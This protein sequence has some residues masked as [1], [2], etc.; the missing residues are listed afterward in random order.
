MLLK[1]NMIPGNKINYFFIIFILCFFKNLNA[2]EKIISTPL[3]NLKDLKPSFE[4]LEEKNEIIIN[5]QK[6][7]R[8]KIIYCLHL[9]RY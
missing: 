7:K 4:E 3:I 1:K 5:Q 8:K 9:M 6:K 2:E